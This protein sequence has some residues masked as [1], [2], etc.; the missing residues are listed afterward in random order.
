MEKKE[1]MKKKMI[2]LCILVL[3]AVVLTAAGIW[4]YHYTKPFCTMEAVEHMGQREGVSMDNILVEIEYR[5]ITGGE[6]RD[7]CLYVFE[8]GDVYSGYCINYRDMNVV[9][10]MENNERIKYY[11]DRDGPMSRFS[12][13]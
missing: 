3:L 6:Y 10:N 4:Y 8:N 5:T 9:K 12:T 2:I 11:Y 7:N 13:N 1:N